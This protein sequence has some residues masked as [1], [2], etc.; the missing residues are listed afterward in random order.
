MHLL[1]DWNAL[2]PEQ[3]SVPGPY[4]QELARYKEVLV[5]IEQAAKGCNAVGAFIA[6]S[7]PRP[8]W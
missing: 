5:L 8:G 3:V 2:K 4:G 6:N 7:H 1:N